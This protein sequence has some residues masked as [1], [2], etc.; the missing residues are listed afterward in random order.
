MGPNNLNFEDFQGKIRFGDQAKT[1]IQE[2]LHKKNGFP[3]RVQGGEPK[4]NLGGVRDW[5]SNDWLV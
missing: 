3:F 4:L 1:K 5:T 2:I